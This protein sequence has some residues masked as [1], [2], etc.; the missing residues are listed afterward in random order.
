MDSPSIDQVHFDTSYYLDPDGPI[1][2]EG[3][4]VIGN[5]GSGCPG[6]AVDRSALKS[7]SDAEG[8]WGELIRLK[9]NH[10]IVVRIGARSEK[11]R[12]EH[13]CLHGQANPEQPN[14]STKE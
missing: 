12:C 7:S 4:R 8:R 5:G 9:T 11:F 13:E 2:V 14:P 6:P 3:L 1:A 10:K